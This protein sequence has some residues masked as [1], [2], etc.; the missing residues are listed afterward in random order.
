MEARTDGQGGATSVRKT[1]GWHVYSD[2][3]TSSTVVVDKP[4]AGYKRNSEEGER[5][6]ENKKRYCVGRSL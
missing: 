6:G 1:D 3:D 2:M 4:K 5:G